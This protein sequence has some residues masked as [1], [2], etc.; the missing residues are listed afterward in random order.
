L[1]QGGSQAKALQ[2]AQRDLLQVTTHNKVYWTD[3]RQCDPKKTPLEHYQHPVYW[4]AFLL[5]GKLT[6]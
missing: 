2:H 6:Y 3:C 1:N 5:V 4:V